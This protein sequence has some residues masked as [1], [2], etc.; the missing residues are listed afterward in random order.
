[1]KEHYVR[2]RETLPGG[3]LAG[4]L[5]GNQLPAVGAAALLLAACSS[6]GSS[7]G[8][9][10]TLKVGA[11]LPLTGSLAQLGPAAVGGAKLAA[12]QINDAGFK[13]KLTIKDSG[14]TT[15]DVASS[16]AKS[17]LSAGNTAFIAPESSAVVKTVFNQLTDAKTPFVS[18]AATDPTLTTS[19]QNPDHYFWR[20]VP[21]DLLQGNALGNKIVQDGHKTV[22]VLYMNEAYGQGLNKQVTATLKAQGVNVAADVPFTPNSAN[23]NTEVSSVLAPNP[24]ALV[25]ISFDEIKAIA[26]TL[27]QNNY[28]F[29]KVY[30][31]DGNNGIMTD[32][33]SVDIKGMQF[34]TPG[35]K[36]PDA[37]AAQVK[38]AYG[39]SMQSTSYAAESYDAMNVIALA[40]AQ[41]KSTDGTKIRDNLKKVSEGGTK[42][43]SFKACY[44]L[45]K[46]GKDIDYE[47]E[48]GP[49]NFNSNGDVTKASISFYK[50][51]STP[52]KNDTPWQSQITA[53]L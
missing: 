51:T 49:I 20:T 47:G 38:K 45:I 40:S 10:D 24:D 32:T 19:K 39:K 8:G 13:V 21:S 17:L 2:R 7:S 22:S 50:T 11:I 18:P 36:A 25:V 52:K 31:T 3:S 35:V 4:S 23:L 1:M 29:D 48:S 43:T 46:D 41:A 42:C 15:T 12:Q 30:G 16:S 6:G 44:K 33:D 27:Q 28:S 26:A 14:D 5:A 9:S 37:F 34:S 53:S